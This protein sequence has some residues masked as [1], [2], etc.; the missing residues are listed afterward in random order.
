MKVRG[1]VLAV[2][3]AFLIILA[4]LQHIFMF[5]PVLHLALYLAVLGAVALVPG[6]WLSFRQGGQRS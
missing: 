5:V 6:V 3:G 4:A 1:P 2:V